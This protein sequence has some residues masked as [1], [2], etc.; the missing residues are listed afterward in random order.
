MRHDKEIT[1]KHKKGITRIK[2]ERSFNVFDIKGI[3]FKK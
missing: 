2:K 3:L 1:K